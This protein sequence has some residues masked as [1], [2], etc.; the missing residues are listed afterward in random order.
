MYRDVLESIGLLRRREGGRRSGMRFCACVV[1]WALLL[2]AGCATS[3]V[4]NARLARF[5][6]AEGYR[7]RNLRA[8][9]HNSDS[10][11]VILTFSGGGTRAASLAYG[12]LEQLRDTRIRWEGEERSLLDE[13]DVI[14]SVSGGSLPAAYYGLFGQRVFEDFPEQVLYTNLQGTLIRRML[15]PPDN[16]KMLSPLYTRTDILAGRLDEHIFEGKTFSDLLA[17][18]HRPYLIINATDISVG[19][20]F[21]F[22][23][24]QFD[25]LYSDL[26]SYHVGHAVAASAAFPGAFPPMTVRNHER[27]P[28]YA[29][30]GWAADALADGAA[31]TVAYRQAS[32]F[33]S[34]GEPGRG[35]IHLSDGGVADNLGLLPVLFLLRRTA[36]GYGAPSG[37]LLEKARRVLILTVNAQVKAPRAWD[38]VQSPVG[39]VNTLFSAGTTP[40][41]NFSDAQIEYLKLFLENRDLRAQLAEQEPGGAGEALPEMHFVE[42]SFDGVTDPVE[43]EALNAMPTSFALKREQVDRLRSAAGGILEGHAKFQAFLSGLEESSR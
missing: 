23:Q 5:D 16:V 34:Y 31:D 29:L 10:L 7:I 33:A 32:S 22:T 13:V 24:D 20:R 11:V 28:D 21:E 41:S 15:L 42:V 39:L 43:R 3:P 6:P 27:G 18:G 19:A 17:E 38:T 9:E 37:G 36:E 30:P 2:G 40:L 26:G 4:T 12:V 35:Y 1:L 8:G 25:Q 14:S